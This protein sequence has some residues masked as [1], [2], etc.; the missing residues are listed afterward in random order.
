MGF[1]ANSRRGKLVNIVLTFSE[2]I[3]LFG[4]QNLG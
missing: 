3:A 2:P 1:L 4:L